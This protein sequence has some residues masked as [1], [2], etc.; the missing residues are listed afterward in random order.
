MEQY[1]ISS[2]ADLQVNKN[3]A[4]TVQNRLNSLLLVFF[5]LVLS[6]LTATAQET[7]TVIKMKTAAPVGTILRI[8]TQPYGEATV[9]GVDAD[10]YF[11]QYIVTAETEEI[12]VTGPLTSLE[13]Y[14]CQ[15]TDL[16]IVSAPSLSI[17]KCYKNNLQTLDVSK[18]QELTVLE[19]HNNQLSTLDVSTNKKLESLKAYSNK[20]QTLTTGE[21][22]SKLTR[23]ECGNNQLTTLDVSKCIKLVDLYAEQNKLTT[24]DLSKNTKLWWIKVFSNFIEG[25]KMD[26][27]IEN[28][29]TPTQGSPM[30]YIVDTRDKNEGNKCYMKDV[31]AAREKGWVVCDWL[32]GTETPN[33]T[34][35]LYFGLDYEPNICNNSIMLKTSRNVGETITLDITPDEGDIV[36]TGIEENGPYTGKQTYTLTSRTL[37]IRGGVKSL[38]CSDN[39]LTEISFSDRN[40]ITKLDCSKNQISSLALNNLEKLTMLHCQDNILSELNLTG[41]TALLRVDCYHNKLRAQRMTDMVKS[42]YDGKATEP[43]IFIIDSKAEGTPEQN[44]ALKSDVK[45][46]TDKSWNVRDYING[47]Y[48][49][50]GQSY[51]GTEPVYYSVTIEPCKHGTINA[52]TESSLTQILEGTELRFN[53][54]PE[55]GFEL[56]ELKANDIDITATMMAEINSNTVVRAVF[57]G[58]EVPTQHIRLSKDVKDYL[59]LGIKLINQNYTPV[60]IG[61]TLITW[62]GDNLILNMTE[63]TVAIHAD[64]LELKA[65]YSQ[66]THLDITNMPN[67]TYVNCALN[68][69]YEL[70]L[71]HSAQLTK[72]SCEMNSFKS[73]DLSACSDLSYLNVYG[74]KIAGSEMTAMIK[75]LPI[76]PKSSPG[77]LIVIDTKYTGEENV[78]LKSD[79][80]L[81]NSRN[82][83]V[84][85]LNGSPSD[86]Q[87]YE[88][89]DV[90]GISETGIDKAVYYDAQQQKIVFSA[91]TSAEVYSTDGTLMMRT[92][93]KIIDLCNLHRGTYIIRYNGNGVLK[94][95]K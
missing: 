88:G 50:F 66:L 53:A 43:V 49:G 22:N 71:S 51:I 3:H 31:N 21:S 52:M 94:I 57:S 17:L 11:G 36:I 80:R 9:T 58:Q 83:S 32:G 64:M 14:G 16:T 84:Y 70:N 55:T 20:L 19:C 60:I 65:L 54:T 79:V 44:I 18:C 6:T 90:T 39:N 1:L 62:N 61:G 41:C 73:L 27:F 81:A 26:S 86:M 13:C 56:H 75:S 38:V 30:L 34:G 10:E 59:S 95:V 68:H 93:G 78:C 89:N 92:T 63:D 15:L 67:L 46:A 77:V 5:A 28:L 82:W 23:I 69:L 42:L 85:N 8:Y 35:T 48:Y 12:T 74:N 2:N 24:L 4:D 91:A 29:P 72:L 40:I 76:R 87:L 47:G 33:M 25:E 45:I 7:N 37:Y